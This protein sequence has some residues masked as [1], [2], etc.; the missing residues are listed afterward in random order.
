METQIEWN[1]KWESCVTKI[2]LVLLCNVWLLPFP[3]S[4]S[5]SAYPGFTTLFL[6]NAHGEMKE[7]KQMQVA[8]FLLLPQHFLSTP[9]LFWFF[10]A[11]FSIFPWWCRTAGYGCFQSLSGLTEEPLPIHIVSWIST[12]QPN[13][14]ITFSWLI[15]RC[16]GILLSYS[17]SLR[18]S[19]V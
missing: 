12:I 17:L 11:A 18:L 14:L 1:H 3:T 16:F 8:L 6:I 2:P 4:Y 5:T 10:G 13:Y 9:A 15:I 7:S 19:R